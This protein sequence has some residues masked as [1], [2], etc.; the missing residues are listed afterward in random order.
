MTEGLRAH[1][2]PAGAVHDSV[3]CPLKP[4]T[5]AALIIRV[6]EPPMGT[7]A[8]CADVLSEKSAAPAAAAGA[9]AANTAVALPPVAGKFGCPALPPA[10][11]YRVPAV[12]GLLVEPPPPPK[13]MSHKP[14]FTNTLPEASV[15]WP[16]NLP[17]VSNALIVPSPKFPTRISLANAPKVAGAATTP[18]GAFRLLLAP[19]ATKVLTNLPVASKM[20]T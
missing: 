5:A 16:I 9:M 19:A 8:L 3:I 4:P 12:P 18:Q 15:S 11:M 17:V 7:V 1:V 6:V 10:V 14:A 2:T 20:S 13:I